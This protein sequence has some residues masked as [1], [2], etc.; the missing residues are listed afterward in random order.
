MRFFPF[1]GTGS[2]RFLSLELGFPARA[3]TRILKGARTIPD[4]GDAPDIA[5]AHIA[6]AIQYRKL[7][8]G[9]A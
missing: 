9:V 1:G 8:R 2:T 6:E 3:H 5:P 4:L 7:D